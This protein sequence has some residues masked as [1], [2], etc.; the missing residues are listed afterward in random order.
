MT[1]TNWVRL[2]RGRPCL[3][4]SERDHLWLAERYG[5]RSRRE[6]Q[7]LRALVDFAER[8]GLPLPVQPTSVVGGMI[9]TPMN[10]GVSYARQSEVVRH[11][12][13]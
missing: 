3:W 6:A 10:S 8:E 12:G 4:L 1:L 2:L 9:V 13:R 7:R 11:E 5:E